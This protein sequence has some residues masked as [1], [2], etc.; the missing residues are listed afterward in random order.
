MEKEQDPVTMKLSL[1]EFIRA[2]PNEFSPFQLFSAESYRR[3]V[4]L[5]TRQVCSRVFIL[6]IPEG[7][8]YGL[9][10]PL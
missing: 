10:S 8:F 4:Q 6:I 7:L 1:N 2:L 3:G 5:E 9:S